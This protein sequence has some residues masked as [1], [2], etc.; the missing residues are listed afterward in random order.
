MTLS[1]AN[2]RHRAAAQRSDRCGALGYRALCRE[3]RA[4]RRLRA[5]LLAHRV[6]FVRGQALTAREQ[7][8]F[9]RRL[10]PLTQGHPTLPVVDGEELILDLDSLAG[11][12][13]T[14]GTPTSPSSTGHRCSPSSAPWCCPEVGGDTLWANTVAGYADLPDDLR[15]AGRRVAGGA[16]ERPRLRPPRP[17]GAAD[18]IGDERLANL[19]GLRL[20]GLRDRAPGRPRPPRDG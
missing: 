11:G 12:P 4:D 2:R 9:A 18:E 3:R 13:P 7:I 16:F 17:G 20:R 19:A 10:G 8:D 15:H 14:T 5:A 1:G 6:V